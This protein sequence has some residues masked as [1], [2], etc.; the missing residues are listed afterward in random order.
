MNPPYCYSE[1][2]CSKC[3]EN[4]CCPYSTTILNEKL[5]NK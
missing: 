4:A 5:K 2:L 3:I 1:L